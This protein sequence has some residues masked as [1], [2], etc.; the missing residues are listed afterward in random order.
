MIFMTRFIWIV[1]VGLSLI[2]TACDI[3]DN[4]ALPGEKFTRIFDSADFGQNYLPLDVVQTDD[5]GYLVLAETRDENASLFPLTY[6]MKIDADGQFESERL[7]SADFVSPSAS[8]MRVGGS[9]YF[10]CMNGVSLS[11]KLMQVN[12]AG[13]TSEVNE[14]ANLSY[15]LHCSLDANGQHFLLLSYDEQE[16]K[17]VFSRIDASGNFNEA[18]S[19]SFEVGIGAEVEEPIVRHLSRSGKIQPFFT[20][21]TNGGKYFFNGYF[22]FNISL[23]F[24][25]FSADESNR[26]NLL[27]GYRDE[28]C[29]SALRHLSGNNFTVARFESGENFL[30]PIT[31][32]DATTSNEDGDGVLNSTDN[33][34]GNPILEITPDA[35]MRILQLTLGGREVLLYATDTKSK[36]IAIYAYDATDG[37]L[38]ATRY[39]GFEIPYEFGGICP[40]A[41]G[42]L[43]IVGTAYVAGRFPR[44]ALFKLSAE[45]ANALGIL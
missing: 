23:V 26:P 17:T 27:E 9:Y 39:L 43:A 34:G 30:N 24:V 16:K 21:H 36:Q 7:L 44:I 35:K 45:D 32:I 15:P 28:E 20:G 33:M 31:E 11:P 1:L 37:S 2:F 10:F 41:D 29:L 6:V 13:E 19:R 12:Q 5:G 14:I 8:L 18:Q 25:D 22:N 4:E 42:G 38:I 40:T 3:S